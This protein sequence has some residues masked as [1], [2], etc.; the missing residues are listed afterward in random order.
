MCTGVP[1][2][3]R[4]RLTASSMAMPRASSASILLITSPARMPRRAAGVPS[5]GETTVMFPSI[6]CTVM[7]RP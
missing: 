7:P 4:R 6:D 5:N 1:L 3:P 2:G